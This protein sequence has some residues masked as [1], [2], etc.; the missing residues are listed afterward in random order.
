M[1]SVPHLPRG[2]TPLPE[3]LQELLVTQGVH[4]LPE[5]LVVICRELACFSES[6]QR[7]LLPDALIAVD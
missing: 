2:L 6:L 5:A 3:I 4:R 1:V 7:T